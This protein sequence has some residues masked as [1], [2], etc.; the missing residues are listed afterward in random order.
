MQ[1]TLNPAR[2]GALMTPVTPD[3]LHRLAG[4]A[5]LL[6]GALLLVATA[7]RGGLIPE[8]A[9]THAIAPP[10]SALELFTLTALYLRQ[11]DRTGVLGL[12]GY[13]VNL[14]GLAGLFAVE[15][16]THAIFPYLSGS[17]RDELLAG[18]TRGFLLTIAL[19]FLLGVVLFS[20]TSLRA[21]VFPVPAVVL[22]LV[23]FAPAALRG[24]VP[25]A[26]YLAGL[27]IGGLGILWL[28]AAL[29]RPLGAREAPFI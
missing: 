14:L 7:R 26:V 22:Y 3:A 28:S 6:G 4:W 8:N 19:T 21:R 15:F 5:G 2:R 29:V 23:G 27:T 20:V 16:A 17:T 24:I 12:V 1:T 9:F 11:R 13:A 10:A 18:P 25:E